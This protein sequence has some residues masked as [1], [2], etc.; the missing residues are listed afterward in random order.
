M[1]GFQRV[2]VE[3]LTHSKKCDYDRGE[4]AFVNHNNFSIAA[5]A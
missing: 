4:C 3:K 5:N 1:N 2:K